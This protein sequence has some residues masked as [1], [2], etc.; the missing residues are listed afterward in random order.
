MLELTLLSWDVRREVKA[1]SVSPASDIQRAQTAL[2][3]K[4]HYFVYGPQRMRI[5]FLPTDR[6]SDQINFSFNLCSISN[7]SCCL[8]GDYDR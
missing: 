1:F 2:S 7:L 4:R 3:L 6:S 5:L 8:C